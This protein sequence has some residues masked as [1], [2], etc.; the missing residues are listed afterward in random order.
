MLKL[1]RVLLLLLPISAGLLSG[2]CSGDG[3]PEKTKDQPPEMDMD[4]VP[5]VKP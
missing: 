5:P 2:G 4:K 1:T 3:K